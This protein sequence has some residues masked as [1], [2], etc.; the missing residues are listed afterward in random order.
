M[1]T[2]LLESW[3]TRGTPAEAWQWVE[4]SRDRIRDGD[5]TRLSSAFSMASRKVGKS[6]LA[7][8]DQDLSEARDARTGWDP[9]GWTYDQ[10]ARTLFVLTIPSQDAMLY[11]ST[12][13]RLFSA[14]DVSELVA[15]YQALPLYPHPERFVLR[16]AEGLR[17][18]MQAVFEAVAHRNPFPSEQFSELQWNQMI[19][20]CLFIG[21]SLDFVV[22]VDQRANDALARMLVD[23]AKERRAADRPIPPDLWRC[24]QPFVD[25]KSIPSLR[26]HDPK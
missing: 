4:E 21:S 7:L 24:V 23:F 11:A 6:D 16:A 18:N 26:D 9:G 10:A 25:L 20:K 14:A 12:L 13:D 17:T 3:L 19:L 1:V 2:Q 22:G 5:R 8:S 15:L